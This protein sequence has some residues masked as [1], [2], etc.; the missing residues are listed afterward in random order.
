VPLAVVGEVYPHTAAE[1]A[2][3][4]K[5]DEILTVDGLPVADFE[6]LRS[7]VQVSAGR[8]LA[9]A[10]HRGTQNLTVHVHILAGGSNGSGLL[11]VTS[12]REKI[13]PVG[14]PGALIGGF[15]ETYDTLVQLLVGLAAIVT[16]GAGVKDLGGPIMIAHLSGQVADLGL[17]SLVRFIALLSVNL[18]LVNL[19]PIPV[20]DGGHL[21]FY[22]LEAL[23]GRPVPARTQEYGYRVGIAIIVCVFLMISIND[24]KREGAFLWVQHLIG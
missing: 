16:S 11:G 5:N 6:Q 1:A 12:G 24:L 4:Q 7:I 19:L 21:M 18:G 2:R 8:D 20:L 14:L 13:L 23:R 10:V 17:A 22:A 15:Q 9:L 3:L